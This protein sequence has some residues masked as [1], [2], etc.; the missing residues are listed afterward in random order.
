M[1]LLDLK[2]QSARLVIDWTKPDIEWHGHGG[3]RGLRGI[4]FDGDR[5][6]VAASDELLAYSSEFQPVGRWRIPYLKHCHGMAVWERTLYL[7]SAGFD[8]ILGFDLDKYR[9]RWAMQIQSANHRYKGVAFDPMSDDGPLMLNKLHINSVSCSAHGMYVSGL[10]TG[11]ML[12]FNGTDI[13]MAVTLPSGS[14]DARPF[15]DGV[16]FNDTN[17]AVLRYTGRGEG[18]EDRA[19]QVP[20][21]PESGLRGVDAVDEGVAL[22]RFARGL[23]VLSDGIAAAGSSPATITVYDLAGNS[24][25]GSVRLNDSVCHAVHSISEWSPSG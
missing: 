21:A 19:M 9:F 2:E 3:D 7:T 22:P 11:G 24:N 13:N 6:Y 25:L 16:L 15:R 5:M 14:R 23:C 1:Y 17:S 8:S 18:R 4:A 20:D 12:H 10:R